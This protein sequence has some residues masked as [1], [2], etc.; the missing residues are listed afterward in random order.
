MSLRPLALWGLHVAHPLWLVERRS[1]WF[2]LVM[3]M[4]GPVLGVLVFVVLFLFVIKPAN[5]P[6]EEAMRAYP[7]LG[8]FLLYL[9]MIAMSVGLCYWS[10]AAK[11]PTRRFYGKSRR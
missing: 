1:I 6:L 4:L 9:T 11:R 7:R 2:K 5:I 10:G 3:R 8:G